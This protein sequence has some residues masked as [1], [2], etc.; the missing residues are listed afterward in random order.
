MARP[1]LSSLDGS[2]FDV[3]VIGAG[4]NGSS[5]AQHLA[6]AGYSVLLIDKADFGGA[7]SSRSGRLIGNGM[8]YLAFGKSPWAFLSHPLQ[9]LDSC[10]MAKGALSDRANMALK[11]PER[12]NNHLTYY[13]IYRGDKYK[14]WQY[15]A[16]ALLLKT[17]GTGGVNLSYRRYGREEALAMPLIRDLRETG[18][19]LGVTRFDSFQFNWPERV[20]IDT[21]FNTQ[22]LGATVRNYTRVVGMDRSGERGWR[23]GLRD[24]AGAGP[25]AT[26]Q[27]SARIVL[28]MSG[29]WIDAVNRLASDTAS[30]KVTG[31]KGVYMAVQLPPDCRGKLV[32]A[33]S[34]EDDPFLAIPWDDLHYIGPSETLFEGDVDDIVPDE[35]DLAWLIDE[36]RHV[37]P[38]LALT[39]DDVIYA[40]AGVRPLT[41]RSSAPKGARSR[42]FHDLSADGLPGVY[43]L[44]GGPLTTHRTA[45]AEACQ[46]VKRVLRPSSSEK[47]LSFSPRSFPAEPGSALLDPSIPGVAI[48]D[49]RHAALNEF[50]ET[51][52]DLLFRRVRVGWSRDLGHAA[53]QDAA[54]A[55]ADIM[56]WN[57][58]RV[59]SE[60][61]AYRDNL[62]HLYLYRP[63]TTHRPRD[64]EP[65]SPKMARETKVR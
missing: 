33:M 45:G 39:R 58:D 24:E 50:P 4:V 62:R 42:V 38:G 19:L 21:V 7:T 14:P 16:A 40:W 51:L 55:V 29:P 37:F 12:L 23:L 41:N 32:A 9:F 1:S 47:S 53:A 2:T 25:A 36:A 52:T 49:L 31:T 11:T 27:V 20:V 22:D 57:E 46:T 34:R 35:S 28:N 44:T 3:A 43:A 8:R 65:L 26:A 13:P 5:A 60:V 63:E 56:E 64:R 54:V 48:S 59:Q 18:K 61:A 15:D 30:R 10:K 6:A 17:L